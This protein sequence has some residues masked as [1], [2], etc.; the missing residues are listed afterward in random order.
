GVK[1]FATTAIPLIF[2]SIFFGATSLDGPLPWR[3]AL[4]P[5]ARRMLVHN[6]ELARRHIYLVG[7]QIL[8]HNTSQSFFA[9]HVKG[10][11][12]PEFETNTARLRDLLR[13]VRQSG[14]PVRVIIAD[15]TATGKTTLS[16]SAAEWLRAEEN[17]LVVKLE[18]TAA[19]FERDTGLIKVVDGR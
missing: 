4:A 9:D 2:C 11:P 10:G 12:E 15:L 13:E 19:D 14:R 3:D 17:A 7:G 6:L 5:P 1:A 16:M 8:A 18:Y